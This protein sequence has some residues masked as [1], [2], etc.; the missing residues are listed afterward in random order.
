M[1]VLEGKRRKVWEGEWTRSCVDLH[2]MSSGGARAMLHSWL[3]NIRCVVFEG[4]QLPSL[5]S[6]LTGWGKHSKVV[7]DSALRRAVESLLQH[8]G[9]PFEA[10]NS[11]LGR[12]TSSGP[13]LAAWLKHSATLDLLLLRD[14]R[15][16]PSSSPTTTHT[17]FQA[18]TL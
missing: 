2:M 13:L 9:A 5:L 8:I 7:G 1:V 4:Q 3:L 12:F 6:I 10:A 11:N 14:D 16:V 17:S 18:L 15:T